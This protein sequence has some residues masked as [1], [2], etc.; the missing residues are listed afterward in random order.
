MSKLWIWLCVAMTALVLAGCGHTDEEMAAKQREIDKL[1]A[2]LK[3]AK[4]QIADDQAKF[5][6]AQNSIERMKEQLKAA[7]LGLEKSKE[8][9]ARLAQALVHQARLRDRHHRIVHAV[10]QQHRHLHALGVPR[11]RDA[12]HEFGVF[13][14]VTHREAPPLGLAAAAAIAAALGFALTQSAPVASVTKTPPR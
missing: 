12:A 2:D 4:A 3:A 1:S 10:H 5:S 8:D 9:A 11:G 14:P 13:A 7:G 6:E